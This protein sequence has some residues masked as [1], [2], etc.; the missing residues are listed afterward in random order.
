M[1]VR[2][3]RDLG[4]NRG[5]TGSH[6]ILCDDGKT[7]V[8]KFAGQ[9]KAAVNEFVGQ[10]L[11]E[12]AGLPVPIASL[13]E[14]SADLVVGS[15]DMKYRGIAPGLHQGSEIVHDSFDLDVWRERSSHGGTELVNAGV[16]PG[17]ICHDNWILTSD[18]DRADNHL[19][20][21]VDGGGM[22]L[23]VDFTHGFTGPYWTA[24]SLEQAS[25]LRA[26]VPAHPL[27]AD[28]VTGPASFQPT[29]KKIEALTDSQIEAVVRAIPRSW[30]L[31]D[32][33]GGCLVDF[34]ELRRGLLRS[35]LTENKSSFPNW[36]D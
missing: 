18:R 28:A 16:L 29:L 10:A 7:Y 32:E 17:T 8:V 34:L 5:A 15:S 36:V 13:V 12:A 19:V 27:V 31:T 6:A 14:V 30:G 1:I 33:D 4:V 25:Y 26:L 21:Y 11:A 3:V 23:M 20:K 9:A 24:D 22:Y 35:V 2:G